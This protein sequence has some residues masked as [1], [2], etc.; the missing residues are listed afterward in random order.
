MTTATAE[1]TL[2]ELNTQYRELKAKR[3]VLLTAAKRENDGKWP[4]ELKTAAKSAGVSVT[5][6]VAKDVDIAAIDAELVRL[7]DARRLLR[8]PSRQKAAEQRKDDVA[9]KVAAMTPA[10][11][12]AFKAALQD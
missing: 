10:E 12:E 5:D 7:S 6:H 1:P 8:M 11:R 2:E 4:D 9:A 3:T